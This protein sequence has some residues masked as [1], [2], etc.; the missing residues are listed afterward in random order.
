[1]ATGRAAG[2]GDVS[3]AERRTISEPVILIAQPAV[4]QSSTLSPPCVPTRNSCI[5]A[6]PIN[7]G[8]P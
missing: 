3:N 5:L 1:M 6:T 2:P 4:V 7:A 8:G